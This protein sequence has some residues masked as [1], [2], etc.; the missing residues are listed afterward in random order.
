MTHESI[1]EKFEFYFIG[2]T[3]TLLGLSIQT[4]NFENSSI[5]VISL[6]LIGWS[7]FIISGLSALSKIEWISSLVY[8]KNRKSSL[9]DVSRQLGVFQAQGQ[10]S[11]FNADTGQKESISN[12]LE[13]LNENIEQYDNRLKELGKYHGWK[14]EV[15]KYTFVIGLL[16][17]AISRGTN[18]IQLA[19]NN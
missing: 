19:L 11:V 12:T 15:Q 16:A 6:E 17:V 13:K 14:H 10:P 3:F 9:K 4:S 18:A 1:Q 2:L 8:V 5:I 7:F